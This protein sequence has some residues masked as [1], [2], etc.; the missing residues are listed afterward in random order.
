MNRRMLHVPIF[1][2]R[3]LIVHEFAL[4]FQQPFLTRYATMLE[5]EAFA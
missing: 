3:V 5:V 2:L 1:E 4:G